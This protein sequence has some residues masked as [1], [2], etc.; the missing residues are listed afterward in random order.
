MIRL[1][2]NC[3]V[4]DEEKSFT[5]ASTNRSVNKNTRPSLC[6]RSICNV[7]HSSLS[8]PERYSITP[9]SLI[10]L[11]HSPASLHHPDVSLRHSI[12]P[13]SA[14]RHKPFSKTHWKTEVKIDITATGSAYLA[15]V[16]SSQLILNA[17]RYE[18]GG[19]SSHR[20][21]NPNGWIR[22]L[23]PRSSFMHWRRKIPVIVPTAGE[24]N[25]SAESQ[26]NTPIKTTKTSKAL[27]VMCQKDFPASSDLM[28]WNIKITTNKCKKRTPTHIALML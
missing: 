9:L 5:R 21:D 7:P 16:R 3:Q 26:T 22:F 11:A 27:W 14:S 1:V 18:S 17:S 4:S 20:P 2:I 19:S 24:W 12:S 15:L 23:I 6:P 13:A 25:S 10:F 28:F 8:P